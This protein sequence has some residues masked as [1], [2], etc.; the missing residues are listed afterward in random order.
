MHKMLDY[1]INF[2]KGVLKVQALLK[3]TDVQL[4]HAI[5]RTFCL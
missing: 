5:Y 3:T 1:K 4:F 2:F